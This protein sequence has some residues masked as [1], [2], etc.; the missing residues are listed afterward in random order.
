M[1]QKYNQKIRGRKSTGKKAQIFIEKTRF[2]FSWEYFQIGGNYD[3]GEISNI[4][5]ALLFI[6]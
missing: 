2:V 4:T 1:K 5:L 3:M 6:I